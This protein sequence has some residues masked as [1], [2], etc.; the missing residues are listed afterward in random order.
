MTTRLKA[1]STISPSAKVTFRDGTVASLDTNSIVNC[2]SE[3]VGNLLNAGFTLY[4][5]IAAD[6]KVVTTTAATSTLIAGDMEGTK[7][8][9]LLA[10][11]G[12]TPTLTT[13]TAALLI[14]AIPDADVGDTWMFRFVNKNSG[15][16]TLAGGTGVTL[17]GTATAATNTWTD[18][19]VL[20]ATASTITM[21]NVGSGTAT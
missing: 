4:D 20:I 14:A 10:S 18:W 21:T 7:R 16:A 12:T 2:P 5:N 1:P 13:R 17:S 15:T 11:G 9:F 6:S 19:Q 8:V 3:F